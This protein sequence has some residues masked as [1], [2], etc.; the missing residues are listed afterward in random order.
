MQNDEIA[1]AMMAGLVGQELRTVDELTD[2]VGSSGQ[3]KKIDPRSFLTSLVKKEQNNRQSVMDQINQEA[4]E[5]YPMPSNATPQALQ[6][7]PQV[8]DVNIRQRMTPQA[9]ISNIDPKT[10][11]KFADASLIFAK[12]FDRIS[13]C[14]EKYVK[15]TTNDSKPNIVSN[16]SSDSIPTRKIGKNVK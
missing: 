10:L 16:D 15:Y 9:T 12:A 13:V 4:I 5:R 2:K 11:I 6:S 7:S 14:I 8:S 3:A 1:A